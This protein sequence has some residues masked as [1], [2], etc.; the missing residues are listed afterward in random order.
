MNSI[1]NYMNALERLKNNK[2]IILPLGSPINN[3]TVALE[4]GRK[5]GAIKKSRPSFFELIS[6]IESVAQQVS[7]N[8]VSL[9]N[10]LHNE[11]SQ[12]INYRERYHKALNRELM[13]LEQLAKLEKR[14][15]KFENQNVSKKNKYL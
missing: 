11:K 12:K 14:I 2:P 9:K 7:S 5:R 15:S 13:L 10:K 1:Q 6:E 3:D 4:A 8:E